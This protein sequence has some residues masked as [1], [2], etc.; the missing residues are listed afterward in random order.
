M[1][2]ILSEVNCHVL[3]TIVYKPGDDV[4]SVQP[5]VLRSP[6]Y[7][8]TTCRRPLIITTPDKHLSLQYNNTHTFGTTSSTDALCRV[9]ATTAGE[10]HPAR[11]SVGLLLN[12]HLYLPHNTQANKTGTSKKTTNEKEQ[13]I[14]MTVLLYTQNKALNSQY[15]LQILNHSA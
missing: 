10:P 7:R 9:G 4:M 8:N 15:T 3:S 1:T 13:K 5:H 14:I 6:G 2:T 12:I 11:I